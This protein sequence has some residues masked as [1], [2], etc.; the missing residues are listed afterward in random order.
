MKKKYIKPEMTAHKME[1]WHLCDPSPLGMNSETKAGSGTTVL[2][3][4]GS[5]WDDEDW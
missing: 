4:G 2:G 5:D 3:R 1:S